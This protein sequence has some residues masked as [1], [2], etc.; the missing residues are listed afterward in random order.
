MRIQENALLRRP[1]AAEGLCMLALLLLSSPLFVEADDSFVLTPDHPSETQS[2]VGLVIVQGAQCKPD[3]YRPLAMEIQ[4]RAESERNVSAFVGVPEYIA[5]VPEPLQFGSKFDEI[6]TN[7]R[8][9]GLPAD[10]PVFLLAHSLGAVMAQSFTQNNANKVE[11]QI[12]YGATMLRKFRNASYPVDTLTID[13]T[14]DGLLHVTRQAEAY[15][16]QVLHADRHPTKTSDQPVVI[17]EGL[18]HWSVASGT[19]PSNVRKNDLKAEVEETEA[20][21]AIAKLV[22]AYMVDKNDAYVT[23]AVESTKDILAPVLSALEMAGYHYLN[24]P[25]ESDYPTNPTCQYPKWPD[26]SLLPRKGPPNP[27]PT[28]DCTCGSPWVANVAQKMMGDLESTPAGAYA[29]VSNKDSFHDVSDVRPFHLPHIFSP[30]PGTACDN[31]SSTTTGSCVVETTTVTM[32]IYDSKDALLDTGL[33]P[34]TASEYRTKL[35]SRQAIRQ[36][37]GLPSVD[38]DALDKNNVSVCKSIN[39]AAYEWALEH[40]GDAA[41]ARFR[42]IG[43]PFR[44]GDDVYAGIGVTGPTWIH[45]A[46]SFDESADGSFV[47][48]SAPYFA[49][50]NKNLGDEPYTSTVGYHYCKLL[51]PARAMEWIYLDGLRKYGG[52]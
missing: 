38:F 10:A 32:P 50:A 18:T 28:N 17:L 5:D 49:T 20:H 42:K 6:V 41:A 46:L 34:V 23:S 30:N 9:A 21:V 15:Y 12:L 1:F 35:K 52:L 14:L 7:M 39:E 31:S 26:K 37:A 29:V 51:S 16:H 11:R 47:T 2:I 24:G 22:V 8:K 19:P 27:M 33:Y 36:S 43:Q 40:A 13:G 3:A 4:Q 48:V 44:F 45:K 25:C